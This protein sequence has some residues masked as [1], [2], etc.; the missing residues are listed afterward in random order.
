MN[1]TTTFKCEIPYGPPEDGQQ[2]YHTAT[3]RVL[4]NGNDDYDILE[5]LVDGQDVLDELIALNGTAMDIIDSRAQEKQWAEVYSAKLD[6]E[7]R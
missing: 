2:N 3:V 7:D 5:V 4:Y 6:K 1:V